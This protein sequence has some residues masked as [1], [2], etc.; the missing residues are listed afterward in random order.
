MQ[1]S[2]SPMWDVCVVTS[3]VCS[4]QDSYRSEKCGLSSSTILNFW[5]KTSTV[6]MYTSVLQHSSGIKSIPMQWELKQ[7]IDRN[8]KVKHFSS[9]NADTTIF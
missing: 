3:M 1:T 9:K 4:N 6:L 8:K 2:G 7:L 5:R